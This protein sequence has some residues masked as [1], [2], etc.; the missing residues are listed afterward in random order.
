MNSTTFDFVHE[1]IPNAVPVRALIL[2]IVQNETIYDIKL[3]DAPEMGTEMI[4][5]YS[6]FVDEL[7]LR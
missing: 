5:D 3:Y 2:S 1:N 4:V 6:D 7:L